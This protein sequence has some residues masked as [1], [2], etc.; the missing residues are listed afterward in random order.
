MVEILQ[1]VT[2]LENGLSEL[3]TQNQCYGIFEKV[4]SLPD[5]LSE[6]PT[7]HQFNAILDKMTDLTKKITELLKNVESH[8]PAA[9]PPSV[10]AGAGVSSQA[11]ISP[12]TDE[13]HYKY[14]SS[15]HEM[16]GWPLVKKLLEAV[17][18]SVPHLNLSTLDEDGVSAMLASTAFPMP[19]S[20]YRLLTM[21]WWYSRA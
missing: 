12:Q 13:A 6:L 20:K 17:Q 5:G 4:K 2:R 19:R 9:A 3:P 21:N 1:R 10:S 14:G 15:V 8:S 16:M 7:Q 11:P 18:P